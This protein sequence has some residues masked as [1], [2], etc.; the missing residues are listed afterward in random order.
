L[1]LMECSPLYLVGQD[2]AYDRNSDKT[3][4]VELPVSVYKQN[5]I[6]RS[7]ALE[8]AEKLSVLGND[9]TPILTSKTFSDF[10]DLFERRIRMHKL[11]VYNVIPKSYG[12]KIDGALQVDPNEI[13]HHFTPSRIDFKKRF[14]DLLPSIDA[15]QIGQRRQALAERLSVAI[16][17]LEEYQALSLNILDMQTEY[18]FLHNP[19]HYDYDKFKPMLRKIE[20]IGSQLTQDKENF[21]CHF[22]NP[23]TY[24]YYYRLDQELNEVFVKNP[25]YPEIFSYQFNHI[26][27]WF[28][29][30]YYWAG[31]MKNYLLE[32]A[33]IDLSKK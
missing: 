13:A 28:R 17:H 32:H 9:G 10:R 15:Q 33:K 29:E 2:L 27:N 31:R 19:M 1:E 11:K 7:R 30:M 26:V 5:Q 12:A 18:V 25:A 4:A 3:H 20:Q 24:S 14:K 16:K 21:Y 22:F 23:Q 8:Q 6:Q